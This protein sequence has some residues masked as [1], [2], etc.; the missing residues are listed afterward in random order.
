MQSFIYID[1]INSL[2]REISQLR[3]KDSSHVE[4]KLGLSNKKHLL[5]LPKHL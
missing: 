1:Y 4:T 5:S 2:M 3:D